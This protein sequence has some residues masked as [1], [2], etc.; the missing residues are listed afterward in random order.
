MRVAAIHAALGAS[1]QLDAA[2][3]RQHWRTA[4]ELYARSLDVWQ[5][6]EKRGILTAEDAAKPLE[7][8]RELARLGN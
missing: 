7:V 6:M 1:T 5:D 2:E 4:R 8:T 3:R